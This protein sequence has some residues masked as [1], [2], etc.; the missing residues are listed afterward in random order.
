[1]IKWLVFLI[2]CSSLF[3]SCASTQKVRYFNTLADSTVFQTNAI[4]DQAINAHDLLGISISSIN[5]E[6]SAIFNQPN[7]SNV[8]TTTE[9]GGTLR[10]AGYLVGPDGKIRFP[11]LGAVQAG[12]LTKRQLQEN[13]RLA[14]VERKLLV[15][16]IVEVRL[17]NFKV[18]VLGEVARPTVITVANDK[19]TLL[20]ALGLAG[21]ITIYGMRNNVLVI[22]ENGVNK[23]SQRID[24]NS[25]ELLNSEYYYLQSNDVVYVQPNKARA[26]TATRVTQLL[27]VIIS[28]LTASVLILDRLFR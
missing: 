24:L 8:Q 2:L 20:E 7:Q 19:I 28:G 16:P 6:A 3:Y 27:P 11:M 23:L 15:D 1:M 25:T 26:A 10:P 18:T 21:D 13:I 4:P 14:L 12:G 22:R 5:T 17:L 9:T